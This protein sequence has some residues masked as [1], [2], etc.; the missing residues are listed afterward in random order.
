MGI[1]V[2]DLG[3]TGNIRD[4]RL[5]RTLENTPAKFMIY[6]PA[7]QGTP[8]EQGLQDLGGVQG[9]QGDRGIQGSQGSRGAQGEHGK[10]GLPGIS[11][12]SQSVVII[13]IVLTVFSI[14]VSVGTSVLTLKKAKAMMPASAALTSPDTFGIPAT[15]IEKRD[16]TAVV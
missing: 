10:Q 12:D 16:E 1:H 8:G 13:C 7:W 9:L 14:G 6:V 4:V 2:L 15:E 11:S 3:A 5:L